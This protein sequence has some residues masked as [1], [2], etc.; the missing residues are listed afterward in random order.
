MSGL[1]I[2]ILTFHRCINYGSYWQAK[3]L[4]DGLKQKG[5]DPVILHHDARRVNIAEWKCA[6]Q[7]VL[8]AAVPQADIPLYK[9]KTRKFLQAIDALPLSPLFHLDSP[10]ETGPYDV[11]IVGSDEV[12]NL[13]HPWYR[14]YPVFF[15]EGIQTGKLISYAASFGNYPACWGLEETWSEKLKNFKEISVRDKN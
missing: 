7:P 13:L 1:N 11:V 10:G 2:G 5:H 15:G 14:H 4:V 12:W 8:P 3:C 9:E 6:L